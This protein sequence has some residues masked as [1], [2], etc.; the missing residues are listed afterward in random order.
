MSNRLFACTLVA[1][2]AL[3]FAFLASLPVQPASL[4]GAAALF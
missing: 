3:Q 1:W 4:S 2:F